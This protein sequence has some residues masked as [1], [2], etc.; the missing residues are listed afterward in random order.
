[1]QVVVIEYD[2]FGEVVC[3]LLQDVG[4]GAVGFVVLAR[5]NFNGQYLAI[6]FYYEVEF[7]L[8]LVIIIIGSHAVRCKFLGHGIFVYGTKIYILVASDNAHLDTLGILAG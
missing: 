7:A 6:E 3:L 1:M 2:C 8:L 5:F 4:E